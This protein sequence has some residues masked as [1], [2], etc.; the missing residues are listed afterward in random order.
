MFSKHYTSDMDL[1]D[2]D[3]SLAESHMYYFYSTIAAMEKYIASFKDES[4]AAVREDDISAQIIT[5][6]IRDMD[7][8]FNT[9]AALSNLHGIFKYVNN[10]MQTA[11]KG[12]RVNTANTLINILKNLHEVFGVIGM[13]DQN[14]EEFVSEMKMKYLRVLEIDE[15]FIESKIAERAEA[16]KEKKFEVADAIRAD[17]DSKGIILM[18]AVDGTKW[19]VKALFNS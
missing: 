18:D 4:N 8:D 19:D 14:P 6:F 16:K 13:F 9:A 10:A 15:A 17:L 11:K 5:D 1:L 12:N 3:F 2:G 7:D